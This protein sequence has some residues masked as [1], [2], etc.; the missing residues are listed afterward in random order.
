MLEGKQQ[1]KNRSA[2]TEP[3]VIRGTNK[4]TI[5]FFKQSACAHKAVGLDSDI[6][7]NSSISLLLLSLGFL[8]FVGGSDNFLS[9][10]LIFCLSCRHSDQVHKT[11]RNSKRAKKEKEFIVKTDGNR[12]CD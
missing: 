12:G 5:N 7:L 11:C 6:L 4:H 8:G 2:K 1:E 3:Q 9:F 10:C